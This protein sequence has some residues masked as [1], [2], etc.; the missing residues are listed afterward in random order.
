MNKRQQQQ[1]KLSCS[2]QIYMP[3]LRLFSPK[4]L[5]ESSFYNL[6]RRLDGWS[7]HLVAV[8]LSR[9]FLVL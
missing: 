1:S 3:P 8:K 4:I 9:N 2:N 5:L 7:R 6:V